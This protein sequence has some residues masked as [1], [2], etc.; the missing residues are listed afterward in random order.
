MVA[1]EGRAVPSIQEWPDSDIKVHTIFDNSYG[2]YLFAHILITQDLQL[3]RVIYVPDPKEEC[4]MR[5]IPMILAVAALVAVASP[6]FAEEAQ[7][8]GR[9]GRMGGHHP[10]QMLQQLDK[11]GNGSVSKA[12]FLAGA[13]E[14]FARMDKNGDGVL[15]KD[16]MPQRPEGGRRGGRGGFGSGGA[17]EAGD[18][19]PPPPEGAPSGE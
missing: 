9:T 17:P 1:L 14:R 4:E 8:G 19:P 18:V 16:D 13:E 6:S 10:G 11:D 12:E 2:F 3:V 7:S 15:T 5:R